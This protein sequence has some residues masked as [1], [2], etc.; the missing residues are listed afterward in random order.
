MEFKNIKI[1]QRVKLNSDYY[2][3]IY[4]GTIIKTDNYNKWIYIL[5]DDEELR[6]MYPRGYSIDYNSKYLNLIWI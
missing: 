4:V 3:G 2:G 1:G 6:S 5:F